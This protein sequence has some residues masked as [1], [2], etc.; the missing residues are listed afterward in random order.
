MD[1]TYRKAI[2]FLLVIT[3]VLLLSAAAFVAGFGSSY[4][5]TGSGI[6]P[7][8]SAI[9]PMV[10][11]PL[12]EEEAGSAGTPV[13]TPASEDE[14]TFQVFW[15][16]WDLVQQNFYG[17][18][19]GMEEVTYAAIHGMLRTLDDEYTAFVEPQAAAIIAEDATGKFEGIGAFVSMDEEGKLELAGIFEGGPAEKAGLRAG[20][21]VLAVDGVSIVGSTLYQAISLIRGPA[22]TE[23]T[24]LI[25][26]EDVPEPFEVTVTRARLEIPV[27]EVEMRD[28]DI[29]YIRLYEF[30]AAASQRLEDGLEE[31]LPQEPRGI[32]FDL[33]GNPGGWLD[34]SVE[35]ADMFLDDGTILFERWSDGR[36]QVF[37]AHPGDIGEDVTLVV[38][39]NGAT[40]SAS[41]IVAGA[42][43]DWERAVLIGEPT[44]GKGS[45]Q[46]PFTLSD[47]SELRVTVALWFTPNDRAIH[48]QG[49]VPDIEV[50]WPQD[51]DLD[52]DADPQLDRAVEYLLTGE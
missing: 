28:D 26:R 31:L 8:W 44:F 12:Q 2:K 46:R 40:A 16:V 36:E 24:L 6:L 17:E 39:V 15:E 5:L 20:D 4:L 48:G 14:K 47:G 13:P 51:E 23:V 18:L 49:L 30:N 41:E 37:E 7:V 52:P 21:R 22:G 10:S 50:P 32:I 3:A 34:Q 29:G 25:E 11:P 27:I 1:N 35:V 9:S 42:L 43:Q 19:P 38:L 33:R 45:V